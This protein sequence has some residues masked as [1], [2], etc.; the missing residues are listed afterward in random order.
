MAVQPSV[1]IDFETFST[2]DLRR[3][4]SSRYARD[5]ATGVICLAIAIDTASPPI[6][7]DVNSGA[8]IPR[9][10]DE[11]IRAG[12]R[13]CAWNV[14]F[15]RFIWEH[16][17]VARYGWP[18]VRPDQWSCTMAVAMHWGLPAG[19]DAAA[20]ALN[21]KVSKDK[22]GHRLMLQMCQP[23]DRNE[24]NDPIYWHQFDQA[25]LDALKA[26]CAQD[27]RV[28]MA[29]AEKL[30][31]LSEKERKVWLLD[32]KM[33]GRGIAVDRPLVTQMH[34]LA[35][36]ARA[37][38]DARLV[39]VTG[40]KL[41]SATQTKAMKD[42]L[43][44]QLV[45]VVDLR[46]ET[47][48][49]R[50]EGENPGAARDVLDIRAEAARTSVAKLDA[51][52]AATDLD[53]R[54]RNTLR[55]Y[56]AGR[57]GRWS[58]AGGTRAQLQNLPRP[59]IKN[60]PMALQMLQRGTTVDALDFFFE[61]GALGVLASCLRGCFQ[62][63]PGKVLVAV[64]LS[65]IE[66]RVIAWLAGQEDVLNVFRRGE[67]IYLYT[68]GSI[69]SANRQ[70]G[71]VI[72]LALGFG[73]GGPRF[74]ATA[75]AMGGI[76]LTAEQSQ[77]V[78]DTWRSV[79]LPTVGLWRA[80]E[81]AMRRVLTMPPGQLSHAT[82]R[83]CFERGQ[84][85]GVA[86]HLPGGRFLVYRNCRLEID[87]KTEREAITYD[88]VNQKTRQW[89]P[90]RT[91]GGKVAENATQAVARDAMVE[92]MLTLD[93][94]GH[95]LLLTSHDEIIGSADPARATAV[96]DAMLAA[97]RTPPSWAPDLPVH[98]EGFIAERYRK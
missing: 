86:M 91:Y 36:Q 63:G 69:G 4:G 22:V 92:S 54:L 74:Q 21:L 30:P 32:Q 80:L 97:T 26:Y 60:V 65:Q 94:A 15:E 24:R 9:Y 71:K 55:Y 17:M 58:G 27:V 81:Q 18:R 44:T 20:Q 2:V 67:D 28:E 70:L 84:G 57:T 33:N 87:P 11:H 34:S 14:G 83:I 13:I 68:A 76:V 90:I 61:D 96:L 50:R 43:A 38:L 48:L 77:S 31:P 62:A 16:I 56:G 66:A 12:G 75:L 6:L 88:G 72:R 45:P 5:P 35:I 46:R 85:G 37:D 47:V 51:L 52:I 53:G 7:W 78:V 42:W 95:D 73:M 39:K 49:A 25:K 64:D 79:S 98:S 89:G 10:L 1:S 40:G 59:T 41:K 93:A 82:S 3:S 29:I 23:A 8:S 19:L